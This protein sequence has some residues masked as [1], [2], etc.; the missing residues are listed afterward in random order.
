MKVQVAGRENNVSEV[1]NDVD[2]NKNAQEGN[3]AQETSHH[4]EDK[5]QAPKINKEI[6]IPDRPVSSR[7]PP[8]RYVAN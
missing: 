3:R 7:K 8:D 5:F 6:Y 4:R 2:M 1:D